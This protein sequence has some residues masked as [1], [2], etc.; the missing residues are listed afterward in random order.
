VSGGKGGK[1]LT[2]AQDVVSQNLAASKPPR[3]ALI[4]GDGMGIPRKGAIH[5]GGICPTYRWRFAPPL[6]PRPPPR[7]FAPLP[8]KTLPLPPGMMPTPAGVDGPG[9]SVV[10]VAREGVEPMID[11]PGKGDGRDECGNGGP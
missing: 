4:G 9:K 1:E 7:P 3:S 10:V 5:E 8:C 6:P 2:D 11:G